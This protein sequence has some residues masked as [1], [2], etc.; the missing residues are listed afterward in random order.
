[1]LQTLMVRL[2]LSVLLV[3]ALG[4]GSVAWLIARPQAPLGYS[5][6]EFAQVTEAAALRAPLLSTRGALVQRVAENS[7]AAQA[8][9]QAGAVVAEIDG[10]KIISARQASMI[11]RKHGAGD[12]VVFTLFDEARGTIRPKKVAVIFEATPPK[13]KTILL[14]KPPGTL[15]KE[16]F[17]PPSMAANAAWSHRLSHG[18]SIR[19]RAM[20]ELDAGNC[21]GVAPEQWRVLNSGAGMIHLASKDDGEH[22]IY[23]LV[24][25]SPAQQRDP[26]GYVTGLVHA[27][28]H[29]AVTDTP[30]ESW[31]FGVSSFNF[32]NSAGKAG[33]ALWRLNGD[34]LSVW[35]AGV[36]A[37][38][39]AWAMPVT[40]ATLLSLQCKGGLAPPRGPRDPGLVATA[41][42]SNCLQGR[43][44]D[45]DF[46]AAYLQ[47][48]RLGYVHAHDGE[49]FLV[50]PKRDF[51]LNGQDG[52]GF[53]RQLGGENE[54]LMPGRTN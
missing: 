17:N 44:E 40:A 51:W 32:G 42:S 46:A 37:S 30:T 22:A 34:V 43:C 47:K 38:E 36:P 27:I 14:V 11:V 2:W 21:S 33:L 53:Y 18:A 50:D 29:S 28:F 12:R 8:G 41:M 52:P 6:L 4:A 48:Y 54:K 7:P 3:I 16:F 1:M 26:K 24:A 35:I 23:K 5:G 39:I 15:A 9:I 13:N 49:V 10:T 19:P 25:L 20:P 45:S 31:K